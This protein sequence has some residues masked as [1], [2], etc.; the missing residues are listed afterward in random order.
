MGWPAF[1]IVSVEPNKKE[2]LVSY[3][4]VIENRNLSINAFIP[5]QNGT[6]VM[7]ILRNVINSLEIL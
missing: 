3:G 5:L 7:D 4:S 1:V 2:G 6:E